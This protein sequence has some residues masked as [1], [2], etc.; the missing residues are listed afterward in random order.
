MKTSVETYNELIPFINTLIDSYRVDADHS[1]NM[2]YGFYI[3]INK[4][5]Y[6]NI[7][8]WGDEV[9][10]SL[11]RRGGCCFHDVV[12]DTDLRFT[13]NIRDIK[14]V[15]RVVREYLDYAK[16]LEPTYKVELTESELNTIIN[17]VDGNLKEKLK[18]YLQV[19]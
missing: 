17:L 3:N 2:G 7:R 16:T 5:L 9:Y 1:K 18:N 11:A 19:K 14:E 15:E 8:I 12:N 4:E 6:V 13:K 10:V